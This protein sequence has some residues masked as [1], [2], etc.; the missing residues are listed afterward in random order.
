MAERGKV[1]LFSLTSQRAIGSALLPPG[2]PVSAQGAV[3]G[4]L[5]GRV[6]FRAC[7]VSQSR[8]ALTFAGREPNRGAKLSALPA[9]G[10]LG[11]LR[12]R[13]NPRIGVRNLH[14]TA[15]IRL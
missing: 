13:A 1:T 14:N 15:K 12:A 2:R 8:A 5:V 9:N 4:I 6:S 10:T 11:R 3:R 7:L